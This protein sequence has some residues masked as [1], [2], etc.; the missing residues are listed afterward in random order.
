MSGLIGQPPFDDSQRLFQVFAILVCLP[1]LFLNT[2][3]IRHL[4]YRTTNVSFFYVALGCGDLLNTAVFFVVFVVHLSHG[5]FWSGWWGCQITGFAHLFLSTHSIMCLIL[6][7]LDPLLITVFLQPKLSPVQTGVLYAYV[8]LA[9]C[10]HTASFPFWPVGSGPSYYELQSSGVYCTF[11]FDS[12]DGVTRVYAWVCFIAT[13]TPSLDILCVYYWIR[14]TLMPDATLTAD[15][16]EA[17]EPLRTSHQINQRLVERTTTLAVFH[18]ISYL[19]V[20]V[21]IGYELSTGTPCSPQLDY[22]SCLAQ[23]VGF[24]LNPIGYFWFEYRRK[25]EG[26]PSSFD[27]PVAQKVLGMTRELDSLA[28]RPAPHGQMAAPVGANDTIMLRSYR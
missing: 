15:R 5:S 18:T 3:W 13:V 24:S 17:T 28:T 19:V 2:V 11:P 12:K 27:G 21:K 23:I 6:S 8:L 14:R 26:K 9:A 22:V 25:Q 4:V 1:S 20:G 16:S 10:L 7:C